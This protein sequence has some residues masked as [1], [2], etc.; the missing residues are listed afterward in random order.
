MRQPVIHDVGYA[1][2]IASRKDAVMYLATIWHIVKSDNDID[3][4][5]Q[6]LFEQI[7]H[8][9]FESLR[10][11]GWFGDDDASDDELV[12]CEEYEGASWGGEGWHRRMA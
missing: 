5:E 4:S 3:V 9:I 7:R 12:P 2:I 6:V 1:T 11:K 10:I 8:G